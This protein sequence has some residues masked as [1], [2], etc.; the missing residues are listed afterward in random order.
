VSTIPSGNT[1]AATGSKQNNATTN[2]NSVETLLTASKPTTALTVSASNSASAEA[3]TGQL[4]R[5]TIR[6]RNEALVPFSSIR[7]VDELRDPKGTLILQQPW[8]VGPLGPHE[9]IEITY[10]LRLQSTALAGTYTHT[11]YAFGYDPNGI[12]LRT[13]QAAEDTLTIVRNAAKEKPA[14]EETQQD[15]EEEIVGETEPV[16]SPAT[17]TKTQLPIADGEPGL[18][19]YVTAEVHAAVQDR[20]L[21]RLPQADR[22]G[23]TEPP[24]LFA[25]VNWRTELAMLFFIA[26]ASLI[27]TM[28]RHLRRKTQS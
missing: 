9:Q 26:L 22:D 17:I 18:S 5:F 2:E 16:A 23:D 20:S 6:L 8:D 24:G 15:T 14:D 12:L 19:G 28:F 25:Y 11:A 13:A 3:S 27:A 1:Q 10:D 7:V 4:I 21:S